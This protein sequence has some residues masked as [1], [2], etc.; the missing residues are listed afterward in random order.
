MYS[1]LAHAREE[2]KLNNKQWDLKPGQ[3]FVVKAVGGGI[4]EGLSH[5]A[6]S[7]AHMHF[8]F[9]DDGN[10]AKAKKAI[11]AA[12]ISFDFSK[13]V[14]I[15]YFY[16]ETLKDAKKAYSIANKVIDKSKEDE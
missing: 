5:D 6:K 14:G 3:H 1:S 2:A 13:D 4:V 8:G 11:K 10:A 15:N 12:G 9:Q 7:Q 16:F